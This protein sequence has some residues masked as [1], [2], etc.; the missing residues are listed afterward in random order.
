MYLA[1]ELWVGNAANTSVDVFSFSIM[2]LEMGVARQGALSCEGRSAGGLAARRGGKGRA[3]L[4]LLA[5]CGAGLLLQLVLYPHPGAVP[6]SDA[7]GIFSAALELHDKVTP[8]PLPAEWWIETSA[9]VDVTSARL[10]GLWVLFGSV[11]RTTSMVERPWWRRL[12]ELSLANAK[13]N[14]AAG[15]S[16]RGTMSCFGPCRKRDVLMFCSGAGVA[17]PRRR[18]AWCI[19]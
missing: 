10:S 4:Q 15:L 12:L 7:A 9:V 6:S 3:L 13:M 5:A 2:L 11:R 1:P 8:S 19:Q 17:M 18:C 16:A 14:A